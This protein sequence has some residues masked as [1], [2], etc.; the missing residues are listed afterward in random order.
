MATTT[1]QNLPHA[2][3]RGKPKL[4]EL[5]VM[6]T[7]PGDP[8]RGT[9]IFKMRLV[10][11]DPHALDR[12]FELAFKQSDP[13]IG[14]MI[15]DVEYQ[16]AI[17]DAMEVRGR[18]PCQYPDCDGCVI[19]RDWRKNDPVGPVDVWGEGWADMKLTDT[20]EAMR[21]ILEADPS[22]STRM[23]RERLGGSP[24]KPG[25]APQRPTPTVTPMAGPNQW[26]KESAAVREEKK[27]VDELI[28]N[29]RIVTVGK[30]DLLGILGDL[31]GGA[32]QC[33]KCQAERERDRSREKNAVDDVMKGK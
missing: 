7:Q 5:R 27:V 20:L 3:V 32:C 22:P 33:P 4:Y 17:C 14:I 29:S 1:Q 28:G 25:Q 30:G 2:P 24:T 18:K 8:G 16:S 10:M 19:Y 23:I 21:P 6:R 13:N 12:V 26:S 15:V 31:L 9:M 11:S